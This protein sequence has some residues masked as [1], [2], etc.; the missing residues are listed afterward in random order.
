MLPSGLVPCMIWNGSFSYTGKVPSA[1]GAA[2]M[3]VL[4]GLCR[5]WRPSCQMVRVSGSDWLASA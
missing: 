3:P 5:T 2:G 4:A 1:V